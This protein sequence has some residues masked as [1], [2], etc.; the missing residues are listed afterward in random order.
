M[1]VSIE[2]SESDVR[3]LVMQEMRRR[4]GE[5]DLEP[6]DVHIEVKSKQ[7]YRSEWEPAAFRARVE[8]THV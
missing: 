1:R 4:L 8:K 2:L 5:V 7:N 3:H 6:K